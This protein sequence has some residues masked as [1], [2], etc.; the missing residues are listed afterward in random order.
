L[1]EEL[2]LK[3]PTKEVNIRF[4]VSELI[5]NIILIY[6]KKLISNPHGFSKWRKLYV[7]FSNKLNLNHNFPETI[8]SNNVVEIFKK[9]NIQK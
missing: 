8:Y 5:E 7:Y 1:A 9:E 6:F 3:V 2:E 4:F